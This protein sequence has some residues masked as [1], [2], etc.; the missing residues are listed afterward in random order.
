VAAS[1][2]LANSELRIL[3]VLFFRFEF[4]RLHSRKR[5]VLDLLSC[6]DFWLLRR[7]GIDD[8]LF[9]VLSYWRVNISLR[10][11][12][13]LHRIVRGVLLMLISSLSCMRRVGKICIWLLHVALWSS[14]F[15][16]LH[17][18]FF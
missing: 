1:K 6:I 18:I 11:I 12:S 4:L 17:V 3:V 8:R 15:N 14:V 5:I 7:D 10:G 9:E 16:R 2:V 13:S